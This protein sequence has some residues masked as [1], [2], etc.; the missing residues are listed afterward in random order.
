MLRVGNGKEDN[1]LLA[2]MLLKIDVITDIEPSPL[3][4]NP[5]KV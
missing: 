1:I 2:L 3:F 5:A 4:K